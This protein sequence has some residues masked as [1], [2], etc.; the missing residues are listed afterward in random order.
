VAHSRKEDHV[1]AQPLPI[2]EQLRDEVAQAHQRVRGS[3][4]E[5]TAEQR[6]AL[7]LLENDTLTGEELG[8]V[9]S[10]FSLSVE[11]L[12]ELTDNVRDVGATGGPGT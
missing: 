7:R 1:T 10:A 8:R 11:R 5:A 9:A 3:G 4:R 2:T 12:F 6:E